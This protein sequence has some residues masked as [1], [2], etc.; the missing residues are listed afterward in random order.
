M[1]MKPLPKYFFPV[2]R[3]A[4]GTLFI[5]TG[6]IKL[7]EPAANFAGAIL[8]Y[9]IVDL[10]T[11]N[12]IALVLPWIE[13]AAGSFFLLGLWLEPARRVLWGMNLIFI[14]AISSALLQK[15]P[16]RD[17]GCFGEGSHPMPVQVTLILDLV[18][19]IVFLFWEF[20]KEGRDYLS[21]D[22]WLKNSAKG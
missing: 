6:Y 10:R 13:L 19:F 15:I 4:I 20:G 22:R 14:A 2:F 12:Q 16:I 7:L 1:K 5:Y 8:S 21:L 9:Q 18:I 11:A 17:C 3:A